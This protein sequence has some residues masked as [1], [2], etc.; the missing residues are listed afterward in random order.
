MLQTSK[1]AARKILL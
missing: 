1:R